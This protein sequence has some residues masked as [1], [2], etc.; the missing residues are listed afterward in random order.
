MD[1]DRL[2]KNWTGAVWSTFFNLLHGL[3]PFWLDMVEEPS[4]SASPSASES[5]SDLKTVFVG[6]GEGSVTLS[7]G[8][9]RVTVTSGPRNWSRA[10]VHATVKTNA[11]IVVVMKACT[12]MVMLV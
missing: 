12:L 7:Y 10:S 9:R 2:L 6:T 3:L 11:H 5:S 1:G 8:S 4:S